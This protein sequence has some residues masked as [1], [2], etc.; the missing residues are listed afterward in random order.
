MIN[1]VVSDMDGTLL[2]KYG[3]I[4][5][6]NVQ[7][8]KDLQQKGIIFAIASGRDYT[9]ITPLLQKNNLNCPIISSNGAQGY[10]KDGE[11][12]FN[13]HIEKNDASQIINL[14][15]KENLYFEIATTKGV[16]TTSLEARIN[17][18]MQFLHKF[19]PDLPQEQLK[20][21]ATKHLSAIPATIIESF[22]TILQDNTIDILKIIV[23]NEQG[24]TILTPIQEQLNNLYD[25]N[26]TSSFVNNIEINA[27]HVSKGEAVQ[28]LANHYNTSLD[29]TLVLGD[30]HNDLSMFEVAGQSAA[31]ENAVDEIKEIATFISKPHDQ[32]GVA[33]AINHFL[34]M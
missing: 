29:N 25:L 2:N 21:L 1:L 24:K 12:L 33:H 23:I 7:A 19:N 4:S 3:E 18:G 13:H 16:F 32:S 9:E 10:N 11:L 26:I 27:Q 15:T 31:M 5:T 17:Q 28:N 14:L 6:E 22:D 8:I 20:E 30:N 34:N